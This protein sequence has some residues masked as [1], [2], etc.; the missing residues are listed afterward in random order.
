MA[1]IYREWWELW[2]E[3]IHGSQIQ[4][5][6]PGLCVRHYSWI[7]SN[8]RVNAYD[9]FLDGKYILICGLHKSEQIKTH[10]QLITPWLSICY[11]K[12]M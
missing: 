1:N 12:K 11:C 5:K 3:E 10:E 7:A 9:T 6:V 4:I 8:P 2:K